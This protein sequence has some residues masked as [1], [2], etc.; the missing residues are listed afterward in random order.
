MLSLKEIE[1]NSL[2]E[3]F[4]WLKNYEY[5]DF[6]TLEEGYEFMLEAILDEEENMVD[7]RVV[8]GSYS[9]YL[10]YESDFWVFDALRNGNWVGL[11]DY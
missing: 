9:T 4:S 7:I 3:D 10:S 8:R 6:E 1:I 5:V 11:L 2:L